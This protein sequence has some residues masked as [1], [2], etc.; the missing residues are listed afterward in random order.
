M[1][2]VEHCLW[3]GVTDGLELMASP[4]IFG[5][6]VPVLHDVVYR[7][8]TAAELCQGTDNLVACLVA[9]PALPEPHDPAGHHLCLS[10]QGT[11]ACYHL[12]QVIAG[13]EVVVH[14]TAHL[15]PYAQFA[16]FFLTARLCDTQ[17]AVADAAVGSPFNPDGDSHSRTQAAGE[18]PRIGIPRRTPTFRNHFL[19]IDE[20][21]YVT[22]I[23]KD[24]VKGCGRVV[25]L[26]QQR[27]FIDDLRPVQ[28]ETLR[29]V[30]KTATV[31][32]PAQLRRLRTS[33]FEIE[34]VFP[35]YQRP[36]RLIRVGSCQRSLLPVLII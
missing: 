15:T 14:V 7:D 6:V 22:G 26:R 21:L 9:F 20:H 5:P 27:A 18:L 32:L 1:H 16:L 31:V 4:C 19:A 24:K 13:Y 36:S 23:I 30:G 2:A 33:I 29:Q 17:S 28:L 10:R 11:V 3:V 25:S 8:M 35:T 34:A 12:V